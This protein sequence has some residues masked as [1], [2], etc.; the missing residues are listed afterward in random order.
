MHGMLRQPSRDLVQPRSASK[1]ALIQLPSL[2]R[3]EIAQADQTRATW[4][5]TDRTIKAVH[6]ISGLVSS[7]LFYCLF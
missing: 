1:D 5:V 4:V 2:Q 3:T 6:V 7:F